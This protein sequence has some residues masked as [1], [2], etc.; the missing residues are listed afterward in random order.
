MEFKS[1]IIIGK[2]PSIKRCSREIVD[3]FD[4][5][6]I[7][8][9]PKFEG[10]E[11]L[12]GE[13]ANYDFATNLIDIRYYSDEFK[14]KLGFK[15]TILTGKDSE[16]RNNFNYHDLD[17]STGTLAFSYFLEK[18]EYNHIGLVGF[19]LFEKN[20]NFYYFQTSELTESMKY[21]VGNGTFTEDLVFTKDSGHNTELTRKYMMEM[22]EKHSEKRFTLISDYEFQ[23]KP[24]L[25]I[26]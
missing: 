23:P 2:G 16:L 15:K 12:I 9:R 4:E 25:N 17:P 13:R 24:N 5:V 11:H 21:L 1:I 3:K 26:L 10:Y 20:K 7:C 19:D 8:N 18:E 14:E 22:F 6:A